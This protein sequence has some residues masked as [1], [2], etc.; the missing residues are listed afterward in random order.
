MASTQQL[1]TNQNATEC[2]GASATDE[3]LGQL[4]VGVSARI[5]QKLGVKPA[6]IS[7][8]RDRTG[9]TDSL[10]TERV[11]I[12][13]LARYGLPAV[14]TV[15]VLLACH[16]L[17]GF[18]GAATLYIL[19]FPVIV[20]AALCCGIGPSVLAVVVALVGTKYWF[21]PTI[22]SFRV[23]DTAQLISL[24]AFL[25]A[26]VAIVAMGETRRRHNQRLQTGQAELETRVQERTIELGTVNKS[27]RD[28]SA[29]L[30]QLQD[31]ERRHIAREL[32]DSVGQLLAGLTMNLSAVRADIDRLSKTATALTDSEALVQE[33]SKEVRTISHLLHPPLLDE[34]GLSSAVRWYTEGFAQRSKI[35]VDLDLPADF[36]RLSPE[37]ETAIFRI[38]Q[39]CLTNIHRHS[40]SPIAKIRLLR[41]D[42]HMLVEVEDKG[43][44]IPVEKQQ[45]MVSAGAPGVGIRG[46]RERIRQLGGTL[47]ISSNGNGTVIVARLPAVKNPLTEEALGVPDTSTAAA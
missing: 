39:E 38:V 31:E 23:V 19:L 44:G 3:Y 10:L 14:A 35:N 33:M 17:T 43:K 40:G 26:S 46:M 13:P 4:R 25:F 24:L 36:E 27:L 45:E 20:Y 1:P 21:I 42:G 29:R 41:L 28:L 34:A 37:L 2:Q 32:H 18:V 47:E 9:R 5:A 6:P 15:I 12:N 30:L 22:H 16:A 11:F 8:F 7:T